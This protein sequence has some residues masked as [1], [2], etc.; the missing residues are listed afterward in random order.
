MDSRSPTTIQRPYRALFDLWLLVWRLSRHRVQIMP[1]GR[2]SS[3]LPIYCAECHVRARCVPG[4]VPGRIDLKFDADGKVV[5]GGKPW[6]LF[7]DDPVCAVPRLERALA[8]YDMTEPRHRSWGWMMGKL[9][10][11]RALKQAQDAR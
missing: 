8:D 2:R 11:A 10:T 6:S 4:P 9:E 7:C 3:D 1:Y 5:P